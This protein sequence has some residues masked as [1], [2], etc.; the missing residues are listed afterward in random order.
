MMHSG[1]EEEMPESASLYALGALSQEEAAGFEEHLA[2]GCEVCQNEV[3]SF[4]SITAALAFNAPAASPSDQT[5]GRLVSFLQNVARDKASTSQLD[6]SSPVPLLT[7]RA[8]EGEWQEIF[9]GVLVKHLFVD[10]ERGTVTSLYK[11]LPGAIIP[12]HKHEGTEEC[13]MVEG[14][15]RSGDIMLTAGDYHCAPKGST[16]GTLTSVSAALF[17]I[18]AQANP[19]MPAV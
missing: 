18:V 17:L 14:D 16:Y 6:Q 7:I 10:Q 19:E 8:S 2:A 11:M 4:G 1:A 3:V 12:A 13:L 15:L 5:R 9:T